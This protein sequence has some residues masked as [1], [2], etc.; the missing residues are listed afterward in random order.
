[1]NIPDWKKIKSIF[2]SAIELPNNQRHD[3]IDKECLGNESIKQEVEALLFA[4]ENS[5]SF[6]EE[7]GIDLAYLQNIDEDDMFIGK[8]FG[9]YKIEKKIGTGGMAYVYLARRADNEFEQTAA[10][11]IIKRGMDTDEIVRRFK[12]ERQTLANL[13]HPNIA[14]IIDGGTSDDGLP[15][16]VMEYIDGIPITQYCDL[17]KLSVDQRLELFIKVCSAVNYAHQNLIVHRDLK[18]SNILITSNGTPKLLD[19]GIAK[20]LSEEQNANTMALTRDG[21]KL[22]TVEYASPEQVT[23]GKITTASDVY[24]LGVLLYELLTGHLPYNFKNKF[25]HEVE[26]VITS[27]NPEK[28]STIISKSSKTITEDGEANE[29]SPEEISILR[30]SNIEKLKRRLSGDIDNIILMAL[31]KEPERRYNSIQLLAE[32]I[33]HYIEGRPVNA[34]SD[35]LWYRSIKFVSR[36]KIGVT[37]VTIIALLL[38]SGVAAVIWQAN[39]AALQRDKATLEAAKSNQINKF[40]NEILSSVDPSKEGKDVKV[41]EVLDKASKKIQT[42]LKNQP[43]IEAQIR[44]TLG[45]TFQNLGLYDQGIIQL[46]RALQLQDSVLGQNNIETAMSFKNLALVYHYKGNLDT[47]KYL[48]EKSIE[49]LRK[50]VKPPNSKIAEAL[51]DYGTLQMD[52]SKYKDAKK[53]FEESLTNYINIYGKE[54][55]DVASTYNN[56]ALDFHYLNELDSAEKYYQTAYD[57]NKKIFGDSSLSV[58]YN[59]NNL[60]FVAQDKGNYLA[61]ESLFSKAYNLRKKI[62]GDNHPEVTVN[63]YNLGCLLFFLGKYKQSE[64]LITE[65]IKSWGKKL[66]KNHYYFGDAYAFLGKVQNADGKY[67]SAYQNLTH[68]LQIRNKIFD[69]K[70]SL[71]VSTECELGKSLFGLKKFSKAENVLLKDY[72]KIKGEK[73]YDKKTRNNLVKAIIELY[74]KWGKKHEAKKY[75]DLI[76]KE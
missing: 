2:E 54:H 15:F 18:P 67:D 14:K 16:F 29:I 75:V 44:T 43:E 71:V 37:A 62:L 60:A 33:K 40:L 26:K 74:G 51:N 28:P 49:I 9:A 53:S 12:H 46:E 34:H 13:E 39:L 38:I 5:G 48:Y 57:L 41:V 19:F 72:A 17:N 8:Q 24:S 63:K 68:S 76:K 1:M 3:F 10:L 69:E 7:P 30:N 66:D 55:K 61:A 36:H 4:F 70:N 58:T 50:L 20:L 64:A 11:K 47:A 31:N 27:I 52:L 56:L 73:E 45:I 25:P 32:D 42:E 65:A 23:G 59:I 6:L 35:S 22:M 21:S